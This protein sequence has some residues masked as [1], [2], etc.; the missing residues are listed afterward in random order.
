MVN[1]NTTDSFLSE[2]QREGKASG[3]ITMDLDEA[4]EEVHKILSDQELAERTAAA[5]ASSEVT[6]L[7]L[8]CH[9]CHAIVPPGVGRGYKGKM[10]TVCGICNSKKISQGREAALR[11]YYGLEEKPTE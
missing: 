9:D 5:E 2:V 6:R 8:Y 11:K 3:S 4:L 1:T 10:R 7:S